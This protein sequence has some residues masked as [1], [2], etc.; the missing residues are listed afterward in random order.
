M[1]YKKTESNRKTAG[2][3]RRHITK[4]I[5]MSSSLF[6]FLQTQSWLCAQEKNRVV[7]CDN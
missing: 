1:S 2:R 7:L 6:C 5:G 3:R 4:V